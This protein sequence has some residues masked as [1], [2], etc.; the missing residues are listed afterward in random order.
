MTSN[1]TAETRKSVGKGESRALRREGRIPAIVYGNKDNPIPISILEKELKSELRRVGFFN[2]LCD[3]KLGEEKIRVLPQD[4][5]FHPVSE[6]AEHI[7]FLKV[8]ENT[9]VTIEVPVKFINEEECPGIKLGGILNIVRYTIEVSCPASKIPEEFT[10]DL[11]G[12]ELG[13]SI[14]FSSIKLEKD[15]SPTIT[16]R[17]FIIASVVAPAALTSEEETLEEGEE[18]DGEGTEEGT[19]EGK[20]NKDG[21]EEKEDKDNTGSDKKEESKDNEKKD[22]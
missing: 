6:K 15:I 1:L 7:D 8:N 14:R 9:K 21:K 17:D 4:I 18:T 12:L 19:E 10:I 5:A 2:R 20:E 3:L 16:D 13:D 22:K 11:T